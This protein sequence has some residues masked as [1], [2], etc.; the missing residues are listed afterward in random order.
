ML[1]RTVYKKKLTS[2]VTRKYQLN[3]RAIN[4]YAKEDRSKQKDALEVLKKIRITNW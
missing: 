1:K 4:R 3:I 2:S